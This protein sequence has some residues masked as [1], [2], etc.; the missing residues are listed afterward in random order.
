MIDSG[1]DS[2]C[3]SCQITTSGWSRVQL[4]LCPLAAISCRY[5]LWGGPV[6][7]NQAVGWTCTTEPGCGVDR[8]HRT[9]QWGGPYHRTRLWVGPVPQN[10]AVGWT[11][12]TEPGCGLD[13][14]HG[15]TQAGRQAA[16][17][18]MS[19]RTGR[20]LTFEGELTIHCLFSRPGI[21]QWLKDRCTIH[22]QLLT[23]G[24]RLSLPHPTPR[25]LMFLNIFFFFTTR[26]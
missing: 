3:Q 19:P 10:Q 12:T 14:Y 26:R 7:Q 25:F 6:P 5:S 17:K 20:H 18:R 11:D 23:A 16:T 13:R 15:T 9:R 24:T 21:R 8:Y 1:L 4:R 22:P 2:A